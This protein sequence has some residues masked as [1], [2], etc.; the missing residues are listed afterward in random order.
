MRG[1][2][3]RLD[4]YR[5]HKQL[6][7]PFCS[8][9]YLAAWPSPRALPQLFGSSCLN[10]TATCRTPPYHVDA[11][12][13]LSL[14]HRSLPQSLRRGGQRPTKGDPCSSTPPWS[15]AAITQPLAFLGSSHF[16]W[17][18]VVPPTDTCRNPN[19][20]WAAER[21]EQGCILGNNILSR[22]EVTYVS[23]TSVQMSAWSALYVFGSTRRH[24]LAIGLPS[25]LGL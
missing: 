20:H 23:G 24:P 7:Q 19:L 22:L 13:S 14:A 5:V 18:V 11:L 12:S 6:N 3:V 21:T 4:V 17:V 16:S 25:C 10:A 9:P 1:L 8:L 2:G 15:A